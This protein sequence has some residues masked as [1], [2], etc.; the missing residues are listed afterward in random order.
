MVKI[1]NVK[2]PFMEQ[3]FSKIDLMFHIIVNIYDNND[4]IFYK[5]TY[6]FKQKLG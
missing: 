3:L 5:S 2:I 4:D 6:I 1:V